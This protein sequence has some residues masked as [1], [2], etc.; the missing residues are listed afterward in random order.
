MEVAALSGALLNLGQV[1]ERLGVSKTTAWRLVERGEL[2]SVRIT[3]TMRRILPEDL[4]A[5]IAA[6]R[7]VGGG[8]GV[9]PLRRAGE[10][11]EPA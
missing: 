9:V 10:V 5:F 6:R 8:E 1:A 3:G 11:E 4:E 2:P 7:E